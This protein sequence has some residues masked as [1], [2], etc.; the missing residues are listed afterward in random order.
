MDES[1]MSALVW[2]LNHHMTITIEDLKQELH[3]E[4]N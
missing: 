3:L 2:R 1:S 4:Y